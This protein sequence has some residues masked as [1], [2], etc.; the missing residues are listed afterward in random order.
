MSGVPPK[1]LTSRMASPRS[2]RSPAI[3]RD[4][5]VGDRIGRREL[6]APAAGL[7]VD[8]DAHLHLVLAEREGRLAGG[9][10]GAA[11]ERHAHRARAGVDPVAER[12]EIGEAPPLLRCGTDD[13]LDDQGAG[14]TAAT[15]RIGRGLDGD[16]VIGDDLHDLAAG[17]LGG[18]V[19]IHDVAF[20]VLDDEED[21]GAA[22]DRLGRRDHLVGRRRGEDLAGAGGIEHAA[23]DEAGVKRLVAGTAAGDQRDLS[24]RELGAADEF[25]LGAEG[26]DIGVGSG[27]AI[28]ALGEDGFRRVD[29]LLQIILPGTS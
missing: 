21:A 3:G 26:N 27:K 9:R 19:E 7:A 29:Q 5:L 23:A 25:A 16:V 12:L 22:V 11:R 13:L 24:R 4:H 17:H 10:H 18:H 1:P 20:V 28:E 15:G 6:D 14:D 2:A 8:A